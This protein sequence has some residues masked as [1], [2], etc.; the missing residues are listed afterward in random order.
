MGWGGEGEKESQ[1]IFFFIKAEDRV[2]LKL[3][4]QLV[5]PVLMY[6]CASEGF[7]FPILNTGSSFTHIHGVV[8][9][10]L[11][12]GGEL[13][14]PVPDWREIHRLFFSRRDGFAPGKVL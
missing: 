4:N 13:L 14:R 3:V 9:Q 8:E 1:R 2:Y 11:V 5:Q 7:H 6:L 10:S 12:L